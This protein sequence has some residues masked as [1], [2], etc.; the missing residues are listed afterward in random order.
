MAVVAACGCACRGADMGQKHACFN[1]LREAG[2]V[3]VRPCGIYVAILA[4]C[5][6][7]IVPGQSEPICIYR[8]FA[9]GCSTRLMDQRMAGC[10]QNLGQKQRLTVI[11]GPATHSVTPIVNARIQA[12]NDAACRF[13]KQARHKGMNQCCTRC[14]KQRCRKCQCKQHMLKER[15]IDS[16]GVAEKDALEHW[17]I[18]IIKGVD[19][20]YMLRFE[21]TSQNVR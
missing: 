14:C 6:A 19:A 5:G 20:N 8:A 11:C 18:S 1:L 17:L 21:K 7:F 16:R 2:K 4:R 15:L 9:L 13:L 3:W 10:R 12:C